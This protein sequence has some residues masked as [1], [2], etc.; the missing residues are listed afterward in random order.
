MTTSQVDAVA[1]A[2]RLRPLR[3]NRGL[4][5]AGLL[6]GIAAAAGIALTATSGWLIVRAGEQPPILT[7]MTAIVGVRA[8]GLARVVFRYAERLRSH[9]AALADLADARTWT[10]ARL[11]PLTPARLGRRGRGEVLTGVVDD[12]TD[13]TEASVRV[14]VPIVSTLV[15]ATLALALTT[16][17]QP[18][19]GAVVAAMLAGCAVLVVAAGRMEIAGQDELLAARAATTAVASLVADHAGELKA[20]GGERDA[21]GWVEDA[22]RRLR[23]ITATQA[24]G[25]ALVTGG[26]LVVTGLAAA[27]A[28]LLVLDADL[29]PGLKALLVLTPVALGDA[30]G[31]LT[32]ATR[33]RARARAGA[34]RVTELLNQQPAVT[35][36]FADVPPAAD[37][38]VGSAAGTS[39]VPHIRLREVTAGWSDGKTDL[40]ATDL[41]LPPGARVAITGPNGAGK[42]TLLAVLGRHLEISSGLL[43][44]DGTDVRR[45]P[46]EQVRAKIAMV[47]DEPHIFATTVRENL[48]LAL[49]DEDRTA[50][51]RAAT[52]LALIESLRRAG[53]GGW[54]AALPEGLDTRLGA[55]GRG[56]S[57]GER[58]RFAVARSLVSRRPVIL[59]DEPVAHLDA[60][61]ARAVLADLLAASAGRTV[62][63]VT[64]HGVGLERF[65]RILE[66]TT[67]AYSVG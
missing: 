6:G 37:P 34:R 31:V 59:L 39:G 27:A 32:D 46:L 44:I 47:D 15:A 26:L 29:H 40:A 30:L 41:D 54:Y 8:F 3:L 12:L 1:P 38:G 11:V 19:V 35:D 23:R 64:H 24:R 57:G 18:S 63:M 48:R 49:A 17:A 7:L 50:G 33:A 25:R 67:G 61:T 52:D 65:D 43:T 21:L 56:L 16:W 51:D 5:V 66:I 9:D 53:L 22:Q 58:A 4:L 45:L 10:Y 42:S 13:I 62:V 28:A 2:Q 36:A 20:I 55:G 60:P 14:T